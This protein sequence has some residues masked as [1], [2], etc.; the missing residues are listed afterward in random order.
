MAFMPRQHHGADGHGDGEHR[1]HGHRDGR[2]DEDQ[3][4]LQQASATGAATEHRE[5]QQRRQPQAQV[6]EIIADRQHGFLEVRNGARPR[7]SLAVLPK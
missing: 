4:E 3:G 6:D 2:H 5:Q 7:T 1:R